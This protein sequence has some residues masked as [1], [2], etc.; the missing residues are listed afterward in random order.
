M[1]ANIKRVNKILYR[2]LCLITNNK[3]LNVEKFSDKGNVHCQLTLVLKI[4]LN[5][6]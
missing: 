4:I 2:Y 1:E 6:L 3:D 5:F